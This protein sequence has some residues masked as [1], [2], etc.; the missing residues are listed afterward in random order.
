MI[1]SNAT[2]TASPTA[3]VCESLA[4]YGAAP[5]RGELDSRDV[6][7]EDDAIEALS[8]AIRVIVDG[9][10]VEGTQMADEREPCCGASSTA[11]I[12][13]SPASTGR[14]IASPPR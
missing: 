13:R 14:W 5:E 8:E 1:V 11:S 9:V 6:W 2:S 10:T 7:D 12:P 3:A 4:L